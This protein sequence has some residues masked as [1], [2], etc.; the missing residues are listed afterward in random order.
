[1]RRR[2]LGGRSTGLLLLIIAIKEVR[3][4]RRELAEYR[5]GEA[6]MCLWRACQYLS[7][8]ALAPPEW[9]APLHYLDRYHQV[10]TVVLAARAL[11]LSHIGMEPS[12][13]SA[14]AAIL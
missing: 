13:E 11:L 1:M 3:R 7:M 10:R 14:S 8:A 2:R 5:D 4:A 9:M 6:L 12:E